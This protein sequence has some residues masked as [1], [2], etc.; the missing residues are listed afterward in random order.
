[1]AS[2]DAR[3][4][5]DAAPLARLKVCALE[6][7][8]VERGARSSFRANDPIGQ[9]ALAALVH[10]QAD[11]GRRPS[12]VASRAQVASICRALCAKSNCAF[13]SSLSLA[14]PRGPIERAYEVIDIVGLVFGRR[15]NLAQR[16]LELIEAA[17]SNVEWRQIRALDSTR[18]VH[19]VLA[20]DDGILNTRRAAMIYRTGE[21]YIVT[22]APGDQSVV[23]RDIFERTYVARGEGAYV[24]NPALTFRYFVLPREATIL[25]LEGPEHADAGDW[26]VEGVVGELH[27]VTPTKAKKLYAPV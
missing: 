2:R 3:S 22:Y 6:T 9:D 11:L 8:I 25:T 1:M 13:R 21:H 12:A 5:G 10:S 23:R 4:V 17:P 15:P 16:P 14:Q 19:A 24:K 26:I 20:S 18:P 27:P 7:R